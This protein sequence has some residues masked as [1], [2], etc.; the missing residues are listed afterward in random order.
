[1]S[2]S[3]FFWRRELKTA[4]REEVKTDCPTK[5]SWGSL[6]KVVAVSI[7]IS[8]FLDICIY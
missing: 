1:M 2:V 3:A 7:C 4:D 5:S 8:C 6:K